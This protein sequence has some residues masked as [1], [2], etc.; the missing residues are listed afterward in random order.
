[1]VNGSS[2]A[3]VLVAR[4]VTKD[5]GGLRALD[6][7]DLQVARREIVG[8]IGPNGSGKTTFI[9]VITGQLDITKGEVW[10]GKTN[11]TGWP[12]HKIAHVGVTR[13]FQV[14]K[15]FKNLTVMENVEAAAVSIL[16]LSRREARKRAWAI[17]EQ[18]GLDGRADLMAGTLPTGEERYLEI[19]RALATDPAFMLLD[20]P[21]AGL[22]DDEIEVLLES[23]QRLPT[24][25][26]CGMLVVDHDMRLIMRLC[27]RIHVLDHG[28]TI[29]EGTP[30]EVRNK[31]AVIEAYLGS[32][33]TED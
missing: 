27:E 33:A 21:G 3:D 26:G 19:A 24:Q 13:T 10:A 29:A 16:R 23:L 17:L 31:P 30:D 7:V 25:V 18:T 2:M 9:N 14:V 28:R 12:P 4:G 8:L 6:A 1:M 32:A 5:F 20:E 15:P 11:I 22:N